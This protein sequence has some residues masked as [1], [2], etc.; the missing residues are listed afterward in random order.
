V[1]A[2]LLSTVVFILKGTSLVFVQ[3]WARWTLPRLRIDQVMM[4]CLKY[5]IP[6]SCGLFLLGALWPLVLLS[7]TGRGTLLDGPLAR[8]LGERLVQAVD[9]SPRAATAAAKDANGG[10]Q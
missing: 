4:T 8:P 6:M 9:G 5:L 10:V 7:S 3:M 2:N 1:C